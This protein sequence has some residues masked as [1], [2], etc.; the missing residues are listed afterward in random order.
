MNMLDGDLPSVSVVTA[1]GRQTLSGGSDE[2]LIDILTKAGVPWSAV[3]I[4]VRP[5]SGGDPR[6]TACLDL[7]LGEFT[8]ASEILLYFNRNV[9]PF[10]FSLND[11]AVIDSDDPGAEATEYVYQRMDNEQGRAESFLKKLSPDEGR[12]IIAERVGDTVRTHVPVGSDLV[13]GV[14]GGGD[15]NA[16]LYG[17]SQL[18]DHGITVHPVILKGIPDWDAGVPRAQTLCEN[19][20]LALRVIE[21]AEVKELL[22]VPDDALPLIDRFEREFPGDDFEFMGTLLIRLAL[23]K[24]ARD[25]GTQ[26]ICTGVNLEDI[27]CENMFRVSSGLKP[28]GSPVRPIG[29]DIKLVYPLWLCPKRI[30]DG[31]FPKFS[32]ENYDARYPCFSLGRNLYYSVVYAMQSQFPGYIEQLARGM[33]AISM[34]DPVEYAY[35]AQLGFHVERD[36]P[37]PLLRRFQKMLKAV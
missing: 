9:N 26:Y 36:V 12:S 30:I 6:L 13:V 20:G 1:H 8:D 2:R 24:Y 18:V 11:F 34:A 27:V 22:G 33:S 37:F 4:Y 25:L 10:I 21:A 35:N 29:D 31:C 16:L 28:A 7:R 5:T 17:L 19:Y 32:L 14:S 15:S 3:S 23:A